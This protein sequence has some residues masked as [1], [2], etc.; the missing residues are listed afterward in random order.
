VLIEIIQVSVG[1]DNML[2]EERKEGE[3]ERGKGRR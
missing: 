3:R 1:T 2:G